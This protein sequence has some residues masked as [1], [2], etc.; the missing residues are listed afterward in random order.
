MFSPVDQTTAPPRSLIITVYGLYARRDTGGWSSVSLLIRLL[1][2]LGVDEPAVRSA[3]SRLKRRGLL[4]ASRRDGVAGYALSAEAHEILAE[5]DRHIFDPPRAS[6]SEGWLLAVFS[7]PEAERARRHTLRSRLAALGF[8]TAAPGVWLAPAHRYE[9]TRAVLRR[10]GLD[11]YVDLFRADYLAFADLR[12]AVDQWWDLKALHRSYL[13]FL[14]TWEHTG[15]DRPFAAWV[16][17][18]TD[19]RRLPYLDPGLPPELLPADW[20]GARAAELFQAL[21]ARLAGPAAAHVTAERRG[22]SISS[23][24]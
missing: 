21:R 8:G 13:D 19:W 18:L 23:G 6:V 16:R 20:P 14:A 7:V 3:I 2:E 12:E 17:A 10:L 22:L 11:S 1:G 5:G 4:V 9:L 24:S 15:A